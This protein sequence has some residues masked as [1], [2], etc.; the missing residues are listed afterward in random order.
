[1]AKPLQIA[2]E[3]K[4]GDLAGGWIKRV[5]AYLNRG[6]IETAPVELQLSQ[7]CEYYDVTYGLMMS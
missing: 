4:A 5:K 7:L 2:L 1:M 6:V 3:I